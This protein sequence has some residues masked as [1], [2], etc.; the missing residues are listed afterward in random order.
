MRGKLTAGNE[1]RTIGSGG[2]QP[3]RA[4]RARRKAIYE[5]LHP[6][7]KHGTN[8]HTERSRQNGESSDRFTKDTSDKTGT[9]NLA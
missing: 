8:Q 9:A 6:E 4:L 7:T 1:R 2:E 5:E 3:R